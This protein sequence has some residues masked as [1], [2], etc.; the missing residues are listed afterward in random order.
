MKCKKSKQPINLN[1][2]DLEIFP[3]NLNFRKTFWMK[4]FT[5]KITQ[6]VHLF[7]DYFRSP[8]CVVAIKIHKVNYTRWTHQLWFHFRL[9]C[10]IK[11]FFSW[12]C[13]CPEDGKHVREGE[14]ERGR[15]RG[16]ERERER[17]LTS[18]FIHWPVQ[19]I[20]LFACDWVSASL[21]VCESALLLTR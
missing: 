2:K 18:R 15:E 5:V 3:I 8:T 20:G 21:T 13:R 9:N 12:A 16:R 17:E 10:R 14:R 11:L 1:K 7:L 6:E 4:A 19:L